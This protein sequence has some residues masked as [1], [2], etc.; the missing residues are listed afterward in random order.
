[1]EPPKDRMIL[2]RDTTCALQLN[3]LDALV[4]YMPR[5]VF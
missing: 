3:N 5:D 2:Q 1:V 4:R